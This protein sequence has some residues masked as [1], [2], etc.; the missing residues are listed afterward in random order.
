MVNLLHA[1]A[2]KPDQHGQ[3]PPKETV[4]IRIIL[5]ALTGSCAAILFGYDLGT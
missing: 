2:V 3:L 5:L 1:F 4:N